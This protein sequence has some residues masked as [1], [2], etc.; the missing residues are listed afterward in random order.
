[1][2]KVDGL[3]IGRIDV[4]TRPKAMPGRR[5]FHGTTRIA[6]LQTFCS[7]AAHLVRI[8]HCPKIENLIENNLGQLFGTE[9]LVYATHLQ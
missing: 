6:G 3:Q 7:L 5:G 8:N 4:C 2:K 1:M 9:R